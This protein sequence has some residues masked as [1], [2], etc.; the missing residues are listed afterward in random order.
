MKETIWNHPRTKDALR[1]AEGVAGAG[2]QLLLANPSMAGS[3]A[4]QVKS[5]CDMLRAYKALAKLGR[6]GKTAPVTRKKKRRRR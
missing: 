1:L 3:L 6:A 4:P 2:C 5:A